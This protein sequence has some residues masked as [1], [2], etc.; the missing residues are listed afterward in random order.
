MHR[1]KHHPYRSIRRL[2]AASSWE[3][4]APATIFGSKRFI[5]AYGHPA[6]TSQQQVATSDA[7]ALTG[8][9]ILALRCDVDLFEPAGHTVRAA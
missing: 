6:V 4:K 9:E 8:H 5:H 3:L 7:P 2:V 1:S